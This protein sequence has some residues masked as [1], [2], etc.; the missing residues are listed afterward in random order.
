VKL[1]LRRVK[2]LSNPSELEHRSYIGGRIDAPTPR[3]V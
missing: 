3:I 2:D 1:A